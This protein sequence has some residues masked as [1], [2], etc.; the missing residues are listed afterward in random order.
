MEVLLGGDPVARIT[1]L[2]QRVEDLKLAATSRSHD[3]RSASHPDPEKFDGTRDKLR[4]F[5]AQLRLKLEIN[6]DHF[7]TDRQKVSYAISRLSGT[8]MDQVLPM[9]SAEKLGFET[10]QDISD[11]S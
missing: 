8:A 9:M 7:P 10:L 11:L 1:A 6:E 5:L 2:N 3:K 4:P